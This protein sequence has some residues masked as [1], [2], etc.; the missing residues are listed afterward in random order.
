MISRLTRNA[1]PITSTSFMS[2]FYASARMASRHTSAYAGEGFNI[3]K[4]HAKPFTFCMAFTRK[5][6]NFRGVNSLQ[7]V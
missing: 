2:G 5:K 1:L 3:V 4:T 7:T 6:Q